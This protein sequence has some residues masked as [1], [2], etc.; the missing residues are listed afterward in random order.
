MDDI[1]PPTPK[2]DL[3]TG[4]RDYTNVVRNSRI[5]A[6]SGTMNNLVQPSQ[7]KTHDQFIIIKLPVWLIPARKFI[8]KNRL[9]FRIAAAFM[10][11]IIVGGLVYDVY[12]AHETKVEYSLSATD[13]AIIGLPNAQYAQSLKY[14]AKTAG[15]MF[16]EGYQIGSG[17]TGVNSGPKISAELD[18]GT[19][20]AVSVT[21]PANNVAATFKP[22]FLVSTPLQDSNRVIYPVVG[23]RISDVYTLDAGAVKE[24]LLV[25]SYQGDTL[26]FDYALSLPDGL[27]ARLE[28][29]G[30]LAIY[31][32]DPKLLGNVTTGSPQDAALLQKARKN[33]VKDNLLFGIPSPVVLESEKKESPTAKAWFTFNNNIL[34]VH[35]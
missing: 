24:N 31:G 1:K 30:T 32:V 33:G 4:R 15:Y 6:I 23:K 14:N 13:N 7:P 21:D 16:N 10:V 5:H 28:K 27:E 29:N 8:R 25:R 26:T 17:Q 9:W 11:V 18:G 19:E 2:R 35:V 3:L 34:T 22:K 12:K 20:S